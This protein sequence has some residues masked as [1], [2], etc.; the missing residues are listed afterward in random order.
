MKK[1]L[2]RQIQRIRAALEWSRVIKYLMWNRGKQTY[3][4]AQLKELVNRYIIEKTA[5]LENYQEAERSIQ[6]LTSLLA[7]VNIAGLT[8]I[9]ATRDVGYV[10]SLESAPQFLI[11]GGAGKNIDFEV[12]LALLGTEILLFDPTVNK[13][14][15]NH[16][17]ITHIP[18]ALCSNNSQQFDKGMNL[19]A[20]LELG[21]HDHKSKFWLK[22]DIEG[23]E[24]ELLDEKL[25][26]LDSF[27]QVFIEF[28]DLYKILGK[29]FRDRFLRIISHLHSNFYLVSI[30]SNNWQDIFNAGY[31]FTP[32]TFEVTF[33]KKSVPVEI[34]SELKYIDL[35]ATNNSERPPIPRL[36]FLYL[37]SETK[38]I[39]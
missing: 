8:R 13:L 12:E 14:P 5:T 34:I 25:E 4:P 26:I 28:H 11:S 36:P 31:A 21:K 22:L 2:A 32:V 37:N 10:G 24:Y 16:S 29:D 18:L 23:S 19:S 1:I 9:G 35:L 38:R 39:E 20:A 17:R 6:T 33:L 27:E 3:G 7:P 15:K 30:N